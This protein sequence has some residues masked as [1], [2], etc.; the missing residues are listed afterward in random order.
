METDQYEAFL[1]VM[2]QLSFLNQVPGFTEGENL[3]HFHPIAFVQHL[4]RL[5]DQAVFPF[6]NAKNGEFDAAGF[7]E[8]GSMRAFGHRRETIKPGVGKGWYRSHAGVDLYAPAGT[9]VKAITSGVVIEVVENF[10]RAGVERDNY[11]SSITI[12]HGDYIIRYCELRKDSIKF[13]INESVNTGEEIGE[14]ALIIWTTMLGS[15]RVPT[16]EESSMLHLEM[17]E[18]GTKPPFG[19]SWNDSI[20]DSNGRAYMRKHS[21]KNPTDFLKKLM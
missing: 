15:N 18:E 10:I 19:A 6:E 5:F 21:P 3:W 7:L 1:E 13:K 8:S 14:V 4:K 11:A 9:K 12:D 16:G 20:K 2:E 17:Y